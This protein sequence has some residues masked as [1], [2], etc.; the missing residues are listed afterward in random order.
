[1]KR[2]LICFFALLL[3]AIL[4]IVGFAKSGVYNVAADV[5]HTR[6][7]TALLDTLRERSIARRAADIQVPGDLADPE[8]VRR[9]AGNY[10]AMCVACHLRPGQDSSE[11]SR[12]LYPAPPHLARQPIGSPAQAFW[13]IRHG[14]KASGMP[15]WGRSMED[16]Y[17]WDMVAFL[18]AMPGMDADA[19]RDRVMT[20]DGHAHGGGE[21]HDHDHHEHGDAADRGHEHGEDHNHQ[22]EERPGHDHRHDHDHDAAVPAEAEVH[23]HAD[24][25]RHVHT[26][27]EAS[28]T[29]RA[30]RDLHA[31][32]ARGDESAVGRLLDPQVLIFE[33]GGVERSRDEY[34][35]HHMHGDM[36]FLKG[37]RYTLL[38]QSGDEAGD[39]A[40][41]GS[42]ADI[43]ATGRNGPVRLHSTETLVL[44]HDG[45][46][47]RIVHI[48]W[49]NRPLSD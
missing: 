8:R 27:Q 49:S 24:G 47:W 19:Y 1:M 7:V 9:G 35:A 39:L 29:M 16:R 2:L 48:H 18:Q 12:G 31:A 22:H 41:V 42:E 10:D 21:D 13:V 25:G 43:E 45:E 14:I 32:L 20:S 33:A 44:R 3:L 38:R 40:W 11:L 17:I 26:A 30:A 23:V 34:A 46:G 15:A 36:A 6:P 5:P 4:G 28:A 37:A